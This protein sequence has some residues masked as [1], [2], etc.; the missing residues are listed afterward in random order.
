[1]NQFRKLSALRYRF[2]NVNWHLAFAEILRILDN[3][4]RLGLSLLPTGLYDAMIRRRRRQSTPGA[5]IGRNFK[6]GP[7]R[8]KFL[9]PR[10]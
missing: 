6:M 5:G 7:T 3:S 8:R 10:F 1:M 2:P 9:S 4:E